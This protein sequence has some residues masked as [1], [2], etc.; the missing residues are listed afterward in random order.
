MY[1]YQ[2]KGH[3][4]GFMGGKTEYIKLTMLELAPHEI[5]EATAPG[6][7]HV[8]TYDTDVDTDEEFASLPLDEM[9]VRFD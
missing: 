7:E 2:F 4:H 6:F 9:L 3:G 5:G 8:G 1:I